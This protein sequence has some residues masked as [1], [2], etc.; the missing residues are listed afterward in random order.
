MARPAVCADIDIKV[1]F[2]RITA[3]IVYQRDLRFD[4]TKN[5]KACLR[6]TGE[7]CIIRI[8]KSNFIR[9]TYTRVFK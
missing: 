5:L 3:W 6:M 7:V 4:A 2:R 9:A 1:N 8:L